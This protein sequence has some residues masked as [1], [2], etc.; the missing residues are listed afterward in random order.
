MKKVYFS[1]DELQ[2][3]PNSRYSTQDPHKI[4]YHFRPA[5]PANFCVTKDIE[6]GEINVS[7]GTIGPLT[8][9]PYTIC[10]HIRKGASGSPHTYGNLKIGSQCVVSLPGNDIIKETWITALPFPRG[11]NEAEVAGMHT[12]PSKY[13]DIPSIVECPV[14]F[15]CVVEY[16]IDYYT[17]G[18]FFVRVLGAS[19]DEKV[20]SMDREDVVHWFPTYEVDD[21]TNEFGG[22]VERLGVMGE[23]YDCPRYPVGTKEGWY[24]PFDVW[25]KDLS[26]G[27][28]I[29][30]G[31]ADFIVK[32]FKEYNS[33][34]SNKG[35]MRREYLNTFF[36]KISKL[37][38]N[39]KWME[40]K[41]L[42]E[43]IY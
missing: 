2:E 19:I 16:K 28:Y 17:H 4:H 9:T 25:M 5:R 38:V 26:E 36:T 23:L 29:G 35:N 12:F 41:E 14:N 1:H 42:L 27:N 33:I 13:I 30:M 7:A 15:E 43:N 11:V 18:I 22:S 20:L 3:R 31:E 8:F 21:I 24:Q 40:V 37:I 39:E 34:V 6:T 10:L 32:L